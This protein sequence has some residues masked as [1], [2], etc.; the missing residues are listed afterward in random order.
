MLLYVPCP[1]Q[2]ESYHVIW[3]NKLGQF[4]S[5]FSLLCFSRWVSLREYGFC[6]AFFP[7]CQKCFLKR[8]SPHWAEKST[9]FSAT[10]MSRVIL[11]QLAFGITK[12]T[13][14][15]VYVTFFNIGIVS[16]KGKFVFHSCATLLYQLFN[17]F[18]ALMGSV[19][20]PKAFKS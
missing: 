9:F 15:S 13:C 16:N 8:L 5:L 20:I 4:I 3:K 7:S 6:Y 10:V 19:Q 14:P 2:Q 11:S 18:R 1:R 12:A 17:W